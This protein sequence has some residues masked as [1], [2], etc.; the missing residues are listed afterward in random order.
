MKTTHKRGDTFPGALWYLTESDGTPKDVTGWRFDLQFRLDKASTGEPE[1]NLS[2]ETDP[3]GIVLRDGDGVETLEVDGVE[4]VL[5]DLGYDYVIEMEAGP[6]P[7]P[8]AK[9]I[10]WDIQYTDPDDWVQTFDGGTI[11]ITQDVARP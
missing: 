11:A 7:L 2:T 10:Y 1:W 8:V 4:V 5:E 3:G 6:C 9:K